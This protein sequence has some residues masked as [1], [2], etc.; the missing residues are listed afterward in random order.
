MEK[1]I[2]PKDFFKKNPLK[3]YS[4]AMFSDFSTKIGLVD[5]LNDKVNEIV[6][7][8]MTDERRAKIEQDKQVAAAI[9]SGEDVEQYMRKNHD[10]LVH[11]LFFEKAL[12]L[13]EEA[14]PHII[15]RYKTS[16]QDGFIELAFRLFVR[17]DRRYTEELFAAYH[18][19]R[20]PYAQAMACLLLGEHDRKETIPFLLKEYK[21]FQAEYPDESYD[22]YPLLALY[23]LFGKA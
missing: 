14:A 12:P 6:N 23:I 13:I 4:S 16:G 10:V 17:A 5:E 1:N 11:P 7:E 2:L 8:T 19:I 15:R 21:R 22:Q 18:D 20:N 3:E 9:T